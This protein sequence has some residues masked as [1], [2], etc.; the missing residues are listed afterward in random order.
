MELLLDR[1]NY[2]NWFFDWIFVCLNFSAGPRRFFIFFVMRK[3]HCQV[4]TGLKFLLKILRLR[5]STVE[6][7]VRLLSQLVHHQLLHVSLCIF[8]M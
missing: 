6:L 4:N 8:S 7:C 1:T 3:R 2:F 5:S